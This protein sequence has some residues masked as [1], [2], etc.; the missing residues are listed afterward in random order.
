MRPRSIVGPLILIAI[1]TLFFVRN[2]YPQIEFF[3][4]FSQYWPVI[5]IVWGFLRLIEVLTWHFRGQTITRAGVS[6]GEWTLVVLLCI[7]GSLFYWGSNWSMRWPGRN[8]RVSGV[9]IFGEQ[10]DYPVTLEKQV[11][12]TPRVVLEMG[13]GNVRVSGAD[14]DMVKITG[15]Q[16]IRAYE[17]GDADRTHKQAPVEI[18]TMGDQTVI[19]TNSDKVDSSRRLSTDLEIVVPRNARIDGRGKNGDF[20]IHDINADVE[21]NSDNAGVRVQNLTGGLKVDLRRSDIVRAVNVKGNVEVKGRGQDVD[22]DSIDG[23]AV[24][25]GAYSGELTFKNISKPLRF[26]GVQ[27]DL[28]VE[29]TVGS[30]RI[31]M[32]RIALDNVQGPTRLS[33]R[34][35]DVQVR[36]FSGSLDLTMERGD[37]ELR[38]SVNN[39]GKVDVR[40][41]NGDVILSL[42]AN[43]KFDLVATTNRGEVENGFGA[44]LHRETEG[45][46]G[47]IRGT[48][49]AG[50]QI[51]V[52]AE[53]GALTV[54]R[55]HDGDLPSA[56]P[57]PTAAPALP[58][59]PPPTA[60]SPVLPKTAPAAKVPAPV[61]Q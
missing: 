43:A 5:L 48:T 18:V 53:R 58:K 23:T 50:P 37:L 39:P 57:P 28:R 14:T 4:M 30:V 42:P 59:A 8:I 32:G 13:R 27:S 47:S 41:T 21:I 10:F 29:K 31:A 44:P 33:T 38:P 60:P 54:R 40:T 22:L 45:K 26:D 11:G 61:S 20:D 12:R 15:H 2:L 24:V 52:T 6:G 34:S 55:A 56:P 49:G 7:F 9:E 3:G 51:R 1:G 36:D 19:R 17:Q 25:N 35:R 46:G 16:T